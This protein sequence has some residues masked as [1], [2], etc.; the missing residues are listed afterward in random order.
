MIDDTRAGI[1]N[2]NCG[3]LGHVD[4]GKTSLVK[5]L[6]TA[7]STCA[8]DKH[9]QSQQ[10]GITLDLGF[11]AFFLPMPEHLKEQAGDEYTQLQFTLVDCPGHAS[12]IRTIIG[13]AQI[14]DMMLLVIDA[15]KGIQTQT[16]ECIVIAEITTENLII[17]L[18]KIDTLPEEEREARLEK[19]TARIRKTFEATKFRDAPIVLTAAAVG[20]EKVAAV[21]DCGGAAA[22]SLAASSA[23]AAPSSSGGSAVQTAGI[24]DLVDLIRSTV[25][26]PQRNV[27]MPFYFAVD[28]CFPIKG[29][30]TVLTGTVLSGSVSVNSVVELPDLQQQRKVKSMQ[31]F[32]RPVRQARQGDRVGICITSLDSALIERG[33]ATAP[34]SVPLIAACLCLV[35]KVRFFKAPCR[36]GAKFHV[37]I[38]HTTLVAD[39]IFFGARELQVLLEGGGDAGADAGSADKDAQR[40]LSS[41]FR[42]AFPRLR[43]DWNHDF[44]QQADLVGGGDGTA[45]SFGAEPVQW[46]FLRFQQAVYCPLDSL[47]IGSRL[48]AAT[49]DNTSA[50][51]QCRLAFYGPII[52]AAPEGAAERLQLFTWK[53]KHAEVHKLTDAKDGTVFE[54]IAWRLYSEAGSVKPFLGMSLETAD[55]GHTG[56]I[57]AP[58]GSGDK[59]KVKFARG[60]PRSQVQVGARLTLRF[61]R[62][63]NDKLKAMRQNATAEPPV[64]SAGAPDAGS[65]GADAKNGPI[66]LPLSSQLPSPTGVPGPETD[67]KGGRKEGISLALLPPK[68]PTA[69]LAT[70][71]SVAPKQEPEIAPS[72]APNGMGVRSGTVE[73]L[74][75]EAGGASVAV[76]AGAFRME[77]D[78]RLHAGALVMGPQDQRGVLKGPFAKLGKCKVTF[79]AGCGIA[80]GALVQ[81]MLEA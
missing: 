47:V 59:F 21:T 32:R 81:V 17:V 25:K 14:I 49:H 75:D 36:S 63:A 18:N 35:K 61:K 19:V 45:A 68:P 48:D 65:G 5:A 37:S 38:G 55:G 58:F 12:L 73:S 23:S 9:P 66:P 54:L 80:V 76:V 51:H 24:D 22:S 67:K 29:H 11:S 64:V 57:T 6:S 4:S 44:L 42:A 40:A 78:I 43:F 26:L 41:T 16:A 34:G 70:R 31:M 15:N 20:G 7:L 62:F 77:E 46:A 74:K 60:V 13:G 71:A 27:D 2:C 30:G 79:P 52:E 3:V 8:L 50:A 39:A 56:V 72:I 69:T 1:V 53:L 33:I 28:H 10:R